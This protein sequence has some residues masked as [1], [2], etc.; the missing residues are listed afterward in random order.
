MSCAD[1]TDRALKSAG[2][3]RTMPRLAVLSALRHEGGHRTVEEL[4]TAL[5]RRH[6]EAAGIA[7]S[8]IYRTLEALEAVSL[9]T[10]IRSP[11][12]EVRFEWAEEQHQHLVCA[13]CGRS[14][15]VELSSLRTLERELSRTHGFEAAV[16]HLAIR[17]VCAGCRGTQEGTSR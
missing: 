7:R 9:V 17:G 5:R 3:R 12:E 8:T 16:Q 1:E 6:P 15:E 13:E 4:Q 10:A 2:L 11:Q 14:S